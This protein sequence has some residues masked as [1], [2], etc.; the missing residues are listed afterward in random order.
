[1][2][3][4]KVEEMDGTPLRGTFY[5]EDLQKVTVNDETLWRVEK[6]LKRKRGAV[7]VRWKGW[8]AKYDSWIPTK[9]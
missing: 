7:L 4:Y 3:T 6:V 2:T 5:R 9:S 1:M 8:P